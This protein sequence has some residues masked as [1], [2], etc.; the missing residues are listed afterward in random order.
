MNETEHTKRSKDWALML[1]SA[2]ERV[3]AVFRNMEDERRQRMRKARNDQLEE[4][5]MIKERIAA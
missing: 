4:Q 1:K 2:Y 3:D 5:R